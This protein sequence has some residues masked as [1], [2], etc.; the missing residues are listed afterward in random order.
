ML[1]RFAMCVVGFTPPCRFVRNGGT[2]VQTEKYASD[3]HVVTAL[4]VIGGVAEPDF[5]IPTTRTD[6]GNRWQGVLISN[7]K[8]APTSRLSW[9]GTCAGIG[10]DEKAYRIFHDD[11]KDRLPF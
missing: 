5:L 6:C 2:E 4:I 1:A 7:G 9:D 3:G 8:I 10:F 11:E